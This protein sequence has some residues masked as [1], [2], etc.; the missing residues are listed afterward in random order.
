[1]SSAMIPFGL[2]LLFEFR[3]N[4][5]LFDERGQSPHS[6]SLLL[7]WPPLLWL[8]RCDWFPQP[9]VVGLWF[10]GAPHGG[11]SKGIVEERLLQ[12]VQGDCHLHARLRI[13]LTICPTSPR[14]VH[15]KILRVLDEDCWGCQDP[16]RVVE[17]QDG[18]EAIAFLLFTSING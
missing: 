4:L 14:P 6:S 13:R 1:M 5:K 15:T 7:R 2:R 8:H 12:F 10:E 16:S 17:Q 18:D 9:I 3:V 11:E